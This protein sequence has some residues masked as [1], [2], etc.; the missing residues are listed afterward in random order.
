[1]KIKT[2]EL[3]GTALDWAVAKCAGLKGVVN[4]GPVMREYHP[5]TDWSQ[6]GPIIDQHII[7]LVKCEFVGPT[8][9]D[10]WEARTGFEDEPG[11]AIQYGPTL[12]VAAMRCYAASKLGHEV[13]VPE[14]LCP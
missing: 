10:Y 6:G 11:H 14:D 13:D 3:I 12:L 7:V 9:W 8:Y 5:S 2:S 1:M 4:D